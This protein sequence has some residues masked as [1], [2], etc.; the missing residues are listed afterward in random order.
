MT[1]LVRTADDACAIW[2]YPSTAGGH[3]YIVPVLG[4][5]FAGILAALCF[6]GLGA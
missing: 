6:N 3:A 5:V 4:I 2:R 1:N